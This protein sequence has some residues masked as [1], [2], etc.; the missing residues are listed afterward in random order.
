MGNVHIGIAMTKVTKYTIGQPCKDPDHLNCEGSCTCGV[1][2]GGACTSASYPL[3]FQ[4]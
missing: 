4:G 1:C 2:P 3:M